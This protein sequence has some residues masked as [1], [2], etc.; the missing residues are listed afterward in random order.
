MRRGMA[1]RP[2]KAFW[3]DY[4]DQVQV[5]QMDERKERPSRRRRWWRLCITTRPELTE[6]TI[7]S[8]RKHGEDY[9]VVIFDNS[10][11]RP[12]RAKGR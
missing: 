5:Q 4:H 2:M 9:K 7:L 12:F 1:E 8:L 6:A 11:E 10:D 3:K